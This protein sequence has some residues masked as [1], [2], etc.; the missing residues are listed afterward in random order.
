MALHITDLRHT[1]A[2]FDCFIYVA[3][4]LISLKLN[5]LK[6]RFA[7][8][9]HMSKLGADGSVHRI[10]HRIYHFAVYLHYLIFELNRQCAEVL[11]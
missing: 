10:L 7:T 11:R 4:G 1:E 6:L 2:R 8:L 9:F 3:S 5:M